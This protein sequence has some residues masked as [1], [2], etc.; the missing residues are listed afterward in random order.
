VEGLLAASEAKKKVGPENRGQAETS[1]ERKDLPS[2]RLVAAGNK[3]IEEADRARKKTDLEIHPL[4]E[5]H[6][7]G[8]TQIRRRKNLEG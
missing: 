7:A 6:E 3:K 2:G 8:I 4:E 1:A 5:N